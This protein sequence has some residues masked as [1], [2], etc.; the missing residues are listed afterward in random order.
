VVLHGCKTWP[1]AFREEHRLRMFENR[2]LGIFGPKRNEVIGDWRKLHNEEVHNFYCS[3]NAIKM[4]T[5][6]RMKWVEPVQRIWIRGMY[7]GFW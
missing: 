1:V 3:S 2:L 6:R 4:I 5:S 7:M